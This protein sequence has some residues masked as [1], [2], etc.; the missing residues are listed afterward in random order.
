MATDIET[1]GQWLSDS[2]LESARARLPILYLNL[3]PVRVDESGQVTHI[4]LLLCSNPDGDLTR[5]VISGR[6]LYGELLRD[7]ILRHVEKDLGPVSLPRIPANLS[8]FGVFEYFPDASVTGFRDPRQHAVA[9]GYII[10]VAGD[11][12]PSQAALDLSWVS[13]AEANGDWLDLE[14]SDGHARVVRAAL[15]A[16]GLLA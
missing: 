15:A 8:P 14:M 9:L 2:D 6:V 5:S 4:G 13:V 7:A 3:V 10:P 1:A 11:C 16:C 12:Q